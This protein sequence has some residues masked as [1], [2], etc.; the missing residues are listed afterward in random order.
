MLNENPTIRSLSVVSHIFGLLVMGALPTA[1]AAAEPPDVPAFKKNKDGTADQ[2]FIARHESFVAEAKKG[3][4]DLLLVGDFLTDD[5]RGNN[6][7][8]VK[9]IYDT[10]FGA[11]RPA[12]FGQ[13]GDYTQHVLWR[14]QNGEL[15]GIKPKV[16]ML[17]IG[18]TNGSNGDDPAQ[19]A[20][21]VRAIIDTIRQRVPDARV[22]LLGVPPWVEKAGKLRTRHTAVNPL[23]AKLDDGGKTV[24]YVDIGPRLIGPDGTVSKELMP[25][26]VHLSE[27]GY[28]IWADAV[29]E[30]LKELMAAGAGK[31]VER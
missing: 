11:Y 31:Q 18:G 3:N 17:M 24:R 5:W 13:G 7:N 25:D 23:L 26:G 20:A 19:V 14:L 30:P 9:A 15:E 29:A 10:A 2:R 22:L 27:K 12:N 6:K 4:V 1:A 28:Q 21:A 16:V 8:K